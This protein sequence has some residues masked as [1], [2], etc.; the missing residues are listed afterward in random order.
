MKTIFAKNQHFPIKN[1]GKMSLFL[2]NFTP[3]LEFLR[4]IQLFQW[5]FLL[6]Y[7]L[8]NYN[9]PCYEQKIGNKNVLSILWQ[10]FGRKSPFFT[11]R[12]YFSGVKKSHDIL[13]FGYTRG[14]FEL[15]FGPQLHFINL[16]R[17]S[18]AILKILI[19][20]DFLG[21]LWPKMHLK[22]GI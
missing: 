22:W 3:I 20:R 5:P 10:Y 11:K 1:I 21:I 12:A 14:P 9:Y 18:G 6:Y 4:V 2:H 8:I 16:S 7:M 17:L 13:V 15:K 19:F